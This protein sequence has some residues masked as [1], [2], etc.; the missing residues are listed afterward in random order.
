M[1]HFRDSCCTPNIPF[2]KKVLPSLNPLALRDRPF[3]LD[4]NCIGI[5]PLVEAE[6]IVSADLAVSFD[7]LWEL[8][9]AII[10]HVCCSPGIWIR[11]L[12]ASCR[13]KEAWEDQADQRS[14]CGNAGA[15]DPDDQLGCGPSCWP[16]I[17][18]GYVFRCARNIEGMKAEYSGNT[19]TIVSLVGLQSFGKRGSPTYKPPRANAAIKLIFCF[20]GSWR[21]HRTGI[22]K[23]QTARSVRMLKPE[24]LNQ[25]GRRLTQW[26][27]L[28]C[29]S[30]KY[31]TGKHEKH[32]VKMKVTPATQTKAMRN[33]AVWRYRRSTKN[34]KYWYRMESLT[35]KS[36]R[37]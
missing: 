33:H 23:T 4:L 11:A 25:N 21:C 9:D 19:A 12:M 29:L 30:Q 14:H 20:L 34:L 26:P 8:D 3:I 32:E 27:P 17:I 31:A 36:P 5:V 7:D 6:C 22:G 2:C 16:D 18:V 37:L 24:K 13:W 10:L 15:H 28:I 35:R 1:V